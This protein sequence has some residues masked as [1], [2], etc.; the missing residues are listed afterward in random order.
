MRAIGKG[1]LPVAKGLYLSGDDI[2]R[3]AVIERLMCDFSADIADICARFDAPAQALR[4]A[5]DNL[6][7]YVAE[8]LATRGHVRI[9]ISPRGRPLARVIASAFDAY[10]DAG[11]GVRPHAKI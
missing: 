4:T 1:C 10:L 9:E 11:S 3:R 6:E 8:G 5:L 2:L 7:P